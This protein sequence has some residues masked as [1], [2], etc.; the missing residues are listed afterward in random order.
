MLNAELAF[1][2]LPEALFGGTHT[3]FPRPSFRTLLILHK[4]SLTQQNP[5]IK[6]SIMATKKKRTTPFKNEIKC[7]FEL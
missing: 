3:S 2:N 4:A 5:N 6:P 7:F 1:S